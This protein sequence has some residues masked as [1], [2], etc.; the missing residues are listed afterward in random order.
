[1][2]GIDEMAGWRG[3]TPGEPGWFEAGDK[4]SVSGFE[5]FSAG[6]DPDE[7]CGEVKGF[8]IVRELQQ[9]YAVSSVRV[10]PLGNG[11]DLAR[12]ATLGADARVNPGTKPLAQMEAAS[13]IADAPVNRAV[14]G[15]VTGGVGT[16]G[17]GRA[18]EPLAKPANHAAC[19]V[20]GGQ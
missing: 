18:S 1:M 7:A 4:G 17:R 13:H 19:S 6:I 20:I 3:F 14:A 5:P 8:A 10:T 16:G 15:A 9:L 12:L 11:D 2:G